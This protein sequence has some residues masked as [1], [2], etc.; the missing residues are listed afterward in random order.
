MGKINVI[1]VIIFVVYL[2]VGI[3]VYGDYGMSSDEEMEHQTSVIT[4]VHVFGG[5]MSSSDN[6]NVRNVAA[7]TPDLATWHDRYYGTALQGITVMIEHINGFSMPTKDIFLMRH[8]FTFLNFFAGVVFFYLIL[9]RRFGN[10]VFPLF[11]ALFFI[12]YPRFF[13]ES[14]YNIKDILFVAWVT[15]S[16]Y[17]VIRWLEEKK[18]LFLILSAFTIA[19]AT[20]TRILGLVIVLLA[21]L[22]SI[23]LDVKRKEG[24]FRIILNPVLMLLLT[25]GFYVAITPFLWSSPVANTIDTFNHF[26]HFE[27]WT[28]THFYLGEMITSNVPWHYI[29]VWMGITIPLLY[30]VLAAA[31][32]IFIIYN[33]VLRLR[34]RETN[35][36]FHELFF[37]LLFFGTLFGYIVFHISIYEGWRHA[38]ILFVPF[39]YIAVYGL[40]CVSSL[41][42]GRRKLLRYGLA[43]VVAASLCYQIVWIVVNHPYQYV[44][45]NLIGKQV[46]EKNFTLDYWNVSHIDLLRYLLSHDDSPEIKV[47]MEESMLNLYMLTDEEKARIVPSDVDSADYFIQGSRTEYSSRTT[48]PGFTELISI[49]VDGMRIATLYGRIPS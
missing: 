34:R 12:L 10:T 24:A 18:V 46:A 16:V 49:K 21:C 19:I 26:L 27:Q 23:I 37:V 29:P 33:I 7:E 15:I 36:R 20:N 6:E 41:I 28:G 11:G 5:V 35:I 38:Y 45:F 42:A 25:Y 30:L 14:F 9:R 13:G 17:F 32:V 3:S 8:L 44:Y 2:I 22:F 1:A 47:N 39:L 31:G 43:V 40:Y 48:P 4:Y